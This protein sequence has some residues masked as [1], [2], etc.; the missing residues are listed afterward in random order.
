[1]NAVRCYRHRDRLAVAVSMEWS[2][3]ADLLVCRE[4]AKIHRSVTGPDSVRLIENIESEATHYCELERPEKALQD[5][6]DVV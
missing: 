4:C 6:P 1:M 3:I 2:L 5:P